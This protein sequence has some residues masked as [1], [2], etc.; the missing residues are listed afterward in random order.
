VSVPE[1][2]SRWAEDDVG[3][4]LQAKRELPD[5]S[6]SFDALVARHMARVFSRARRILRSETD[7]DD[8]TQEVFLSAMRALPGYRPEKPF[9]HWLD[10]ITLNACR[11]VLRRRVR[12]AGRSE[13]L[14]PEQPD[15][16]T[17]DSDP[18][19]RKFLE[20]RLGAL[21]GGTREAVILRLAERHTYPEIARR[22]G[23]KESA[24]KMRVS[25]ACEHLRELCSQCEHR[26]PCSRP[27]GPEPAQ[28]VDAPGNGELTSPACISHSFRAKW[29][30]LRNLPTMKVLYVEDDPVA[31]EYVQGGLGTRGFTVELAET[32]A[33]GLERALGGDHDVLI[34]DVMLPDGEGYDLLL[35][36][37]E[38]GVDTPSLFLSSRADVDDRLR[39]FEQGADDY[40][41]KPFAL[42][43]LVARVQAIARRRLG[44][45]QDLKLSVADLVLDLKAQ[46]VVRAGKAVDLPP[47]PFALLALLVRSAGRVV[48]RSTLIEGVWGA[49]A[50][51][52]SNAL[53][54]QVNHLRKLVDHPFEKKLIHTRPGVGYVLED[55]A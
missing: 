15:E 10:V 37:R 55:R 41:P 11:Q 13:E 28:L 9:S 14:R 30:G 6:D 43:E 39:G 44:A 7:A 25:R 24:V 42:S 52:R 1:V 18:I 38:A 3:L 29:A 27:Q 33:E 23:V 20:S 35:K 12:E 32:A 2:E 45:S 47:K 46:R 17:P 49:D 53:E 48:P 16:E 4:V 36:L 21:P 26:E 34:L 54:V 19:L 51:L 5:C 31:R 22:L 40:L 8:V 50:E